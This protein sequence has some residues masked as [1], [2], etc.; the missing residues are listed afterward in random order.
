MTAACNT[1]LSRIIA[2]GWALIVSTLLCAWLG[3]YFVTL[4]ETEAAHDKT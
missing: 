4:P 3:T 1:L 2:P